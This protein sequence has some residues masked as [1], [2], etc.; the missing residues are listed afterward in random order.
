MID[1]SS[2]FMAGVAGLYDY[3]SAHV[4]F[5]LVP[6][7]FLA[8]AMN[9]LVSR[10]AIMRFLG[11]SAKKW[12]S[13]SIASVSGFLI[14]VCSCTILPLFAGI[15][16]RGA[17]LGPAITFLYAGPAINLVAVSYTASLLGYDIAIARTVLS[18]VFA[19]LTGIVMSALFKKE[20]NTVESLTEHAA[21]RVKKRG[22]LESGG[23]FGSLVAVLIIG[24]APVSMQTKVLGTLF[25]G[26]LTAVAAKLWYTEAEMMRWMEETWDFFKQIFPT[27]I[28]GVFVAGM[29]R[30]VIPQDLMTQYA[31]SNTLFANFIGVLFGVVAYFPA[32]VEVPMAKTFLDLGMHKGP[33]LAYLIA[34]PVMSLQTILVIRKVLGTKETLTYVA[35]ITV[36]AVLAGWLFGM[37]F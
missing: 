31:G 23:F 28:A 8:G 32:L 13:Y 2:I 4:L 27:L 37:F 35:L 10:S 26:G 6:A 17:G 9:A 33:M 34:D 19:I 1:V 20:T 18:I 25:F 15:W 12:V 30:A 7:F 11:K 36:E 14:E 16:E 3:L 22:L 21:E 29:L 5:C 24:T